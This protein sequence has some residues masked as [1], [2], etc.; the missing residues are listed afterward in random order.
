MSGS[1]TSR[2]KSA[3]THSERTFTALLSRDG[4]TVDGRQVRRLHGRWIQ[5]RGIVLTAV[6]LRTHVKTPSPNASAED[7]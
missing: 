3:S 7:R 1:T 2:P 5:E 4:L 6:V